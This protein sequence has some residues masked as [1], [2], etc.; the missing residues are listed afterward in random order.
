M[1]GQGATR[2]SRASIFGAA[3]SRQTCSLLRL[4][5]GLLE[6]PGC[7]ICEGFVP[8]I[9]R[10]GSVAKASIFPIGLSWPS[11]MA[12]PW[13]VTGEARTQE[14]YASFPGAVAGQRTSA[15]REPPPGIRASL[16]TQAKFFRHERSCRSPRG[17]TELLRF[18]AILV[19]TFYPSG[20]CY[21]L[22]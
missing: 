22:G 11:L 14:G 1:A 6:E 8:H 13:Y 15:P 12:P 10:F 20:H 16:L 3:S 7:T 17:D 19:S 5:S 2:E 21:A 9:V 18:S 4:L